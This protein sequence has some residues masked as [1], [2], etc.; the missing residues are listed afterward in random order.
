MGSCSNAGGCCGILFGAS[1]TIATAWALGAILLRKLSIA[2]YRAEERLFSFLLGSAC[3]SAIMF[4]LA[5]LKLA[6][7]GV[8]L[9]LGILVVGYAFYS[10]AHRSKGNQFPPLPRLWKWVFAAVFTMFTVLYFFNA[11]APEVSADGMSYHLGEVAKYY[12]AHGFVRITT[13]LYGNLSQGIE[14]LFL[15]AFTYG[16]HSAAAL[17]HYAFLLCLTF[18]VLSYGRR[19]GNPADGS[20]RGYVPLRQPGGGDGRNRRIQ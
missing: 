2:L 9:A 6:R 13:N 7:R 8:F 12:R 4:A 14:L 20:G 19:L 11:L 16:K 5:T 10:G 18:L 1:L 15:H 3:L 17:V